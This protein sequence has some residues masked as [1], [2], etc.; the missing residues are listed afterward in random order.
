M[1]RKFLL[2]LTGIAVILAS[3]NKEEVG[4]ADSNSTTKKSFTINVDN[5]V[6]TRANVTDLTRYVME[7]YEGTSA[8]GTPEVHKEQATGVFDNVILKDGQTYT[9]LFWADYGTP[10]T[11]G[12]N[13]AGNEYN[14][15][16]LK[17]ARVADGK[18]ATKV[19]FAGASKFTVGTD[20]E[21][22]YTAVKL[23]H[24]V[25]QV[26]FMQNEAL[27]SDV[28]TLVVKYPESYSL[29]VDDMS[30]TKIAGE[31]SHSF[32]Y[33]SKEVGTLGTSYII[34]ATG[35]TKTVMDITAT[36]TSG[37]ATNSKAVTAIP[38]E[39]NYR[40][41]IYGAYSNLYSTTLSVTCND[42]WETISNE[43]VFPIAHVGDYLYSDRTYST[44]LNTGKTVI[45]IVFWVDPTD[46]TKGKIV[47]LD[48]GSDLGWSTTGNILIGATS[49]ADGV[50]NTA[51]LKSKTSN[52]SVDY[53]ALAW[54]LAK[55]NQAIEGITWYMPA[56]GELSILSQSYNIVNNVLNSVSGATSLSSWY[57][58][59]T[60]YN[61]LS[62]YNFETK[63]GLQGSCFRMFAGKVRAVSTF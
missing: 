2:A 32:T 40:T 19:A 51:V 48:E 55:N 29:N 37:G 59:S 5:G 1:K 46:K 18:Q 6:Q 9:V 15:S 10:S 53:P 17:V 16:D 21:D 49:K 45:G 27:T 62:I 41:N 38:F 34:A 60:E 30:V 54:C 11:D 25:A 39:C 13:P 35:T 61:N 23:T 50:V 12:T 42:Q 31:V 7:V 3:C 24:A 28:N 56:V 52:V 58:S 47:S 63:Y 20:N 57:S 22:V 43:V 4:N 44:N 26:N 14:A 8:T 36:M 33:S